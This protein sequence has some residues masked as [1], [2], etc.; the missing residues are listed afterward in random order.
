VA[1]AISARDGS[2]IF[3]LTA[4]GSK[5]AGTQGFWRGDGASDSRSPG[6]HTFH[7]RPRCASTAPMPT[8][9]PLT[10][11]INSLES[12]VSASIIVEK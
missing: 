9:T 6:S 5:S 4:I 12:S 10:V 1:A 2:T 8:P 11:R 7:A 3:C